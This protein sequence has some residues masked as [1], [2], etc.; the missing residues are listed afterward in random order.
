MTQLSLEQGYSRESCVAVETVPSPRTDLPKRFR[1]TE[2]APLIFQTDDP[3]FKAKLGELE[4]ASGLLY[5][6]EVCEE[7]TVAARM[8]SLLVLA[9]LGQ[10]ACWAGLHL[11]LPGTPLLPT[12]SGS[13]LFAAPD[14]GPNSRNENSIS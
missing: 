11:D 7:K 4:A 10:A 9:R 1:D 14:P 12:G 3:H 8:P 2:S 5:L 6:K 13:L